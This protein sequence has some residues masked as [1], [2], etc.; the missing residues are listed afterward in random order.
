MKRAVKELGSRAIDGRTSV[1]K[2]LL[3]WRSELIAELGGGDAPPRGEELAQGSRL[4]A[5]LSRSHRTIPSERLLHSPEPNPAAEATVEDGLW[6]RLR[7]AL[8]P[9]SPIH[10][11][12]R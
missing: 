3:H 5:R 11:C 12:R 2:A 8:T 4:P 7:M 9:T 6:L 1:G 10:T